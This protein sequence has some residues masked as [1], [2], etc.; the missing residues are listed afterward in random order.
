MGGG[1]ALPKPLAAHWLTLPEERRTD[2]GEE[3]S[4]DINDRTV[5][6]LLVLLMPVHADL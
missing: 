2:G 6:L 1:E 4:S 5:H 3:L